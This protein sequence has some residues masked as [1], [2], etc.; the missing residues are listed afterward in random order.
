MIMCRLRIQKIKI[1]NQEGFEFRALS[2]TFPHEKT[3]FQ[4]SKVVSG[5][6]NHRKLDQVDG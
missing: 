4:W 2:L 3:T 1:G 5:W 6:A